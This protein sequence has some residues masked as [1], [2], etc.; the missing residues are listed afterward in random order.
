MDILL[1]GIFIRNRQFVCVKMDD[2]E[3]Y[4]V[5]EVRHDSRIFTL[6]T[7]FE[8]PSNQGK[9]MTDLGPLHMEHFFIYLNPAS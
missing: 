5:E 4:D 9:W 8:I 7:M 2:D 6:Y 1:F 3:I